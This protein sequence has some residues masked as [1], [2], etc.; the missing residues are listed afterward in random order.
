MSEL[1][2]ITGTLD[3]QLWPPSYEQATH[4]WMRGEWHKLPMTSAQMTARIEKLEAALR[5]ALENGVCTQYWGDDDDCGTHGC[6]G[7]VSYKPHDAKCWTVKARAAL[8][9]K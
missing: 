7:E 5:Y 9:G 2:N 8:E 6:C 3:G 4:V 1:P